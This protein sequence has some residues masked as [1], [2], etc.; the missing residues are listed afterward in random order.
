M[1]GILGKYQARGWLD[2]VVRWPAAHGRCIGRG[3]ELGCS[4]PSWLPGCLQDGKIDFKE[5]CDLIR[6]HPC[7]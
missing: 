6:K 1:Q 2:A 3:L 4:L 7:E 5:F